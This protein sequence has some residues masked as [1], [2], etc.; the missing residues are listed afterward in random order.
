MAVMEQLVKSDPTPRLPTRC[1]S[2]AASFFTLA[3]TAT[4]RTPTR[5]SWRKVRLRVP[6]AA[7]QAG[8]VV[9]QAGA[10]EEALHRY[11]RCSITAGRASF[12]CEAHGGEDRRVEDTFNVVLSFSNLGGPEVIGEYCRVRPPPYEDRS[13][14]TW[15]S[16][17]S[18]YQDAAKVSR[19]SSRF[20][21]STRV[22]D[23]LRTIGI[24]ETG[25]FPLLVVKASGSRPT[26]G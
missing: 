6:R 17:I 19:I 21:R 23:C 26:T 9:L 25:G 4:P 11:S 10:F 16:S 7:V 5:A 22:P 3:S 24:Y 12:R 2:V 18:A 1:S 13:T 14:A 20:I 8:L 15:P